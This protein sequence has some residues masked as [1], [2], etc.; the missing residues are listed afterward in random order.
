MKKKVYE[1][2]FG[3]LRESDVYKIVRS[4]DVKIKTFEYIKEQLIKAVSYKDD[5][6]VEQCII[7][8]CSFLR[9]EDCAIMQICNLQGKR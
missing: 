9:C 7:D 1:T 5:G 3:R 8:F 2:R 6:Y 4:I